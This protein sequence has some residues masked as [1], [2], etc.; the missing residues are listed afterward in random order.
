MKKLSCRST[1]SGFTLV[2]LLVVIA[3]IGILTGIGI[4]AFTTTR[5]NAIASTMQSDLRGAV[6][7]LKQY[8]L[9]NGSYP[10]DPTVVDN[11]HGLVASGD[12]HYSY[13]PLNSNH[14]YCLVISSSGTPDTYHVTDAVPAPAI[15]GC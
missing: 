6:S 10:T 4:V 14:N 13:T 2:E 11:G 5:H 3:V 7:A 1:N 9:Q 15:G 12:N 8:Y